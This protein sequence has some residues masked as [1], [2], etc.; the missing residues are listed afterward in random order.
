MLSQI[1]HYSKRVKPLVQAPLILIKLD[2]TNDLIPHRNQTVE[3]V[4]GIK[5]LTDPIVAK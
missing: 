2:K 4:G 1:T 3:L 5:S